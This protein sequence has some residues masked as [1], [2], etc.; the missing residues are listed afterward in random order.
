MKNY[1]VILSAPAFAALLF[2]ASG[3]YSA[4]QG[5]A[6]KAAIA[7]KDASFQKMK[8]RGRASDSDNTAILAPLAGEWN[9][10]ATFWANADAEGA[11]SDG[12]TT[13]EMVLN[14]RFLASSVVGVLNIDGKAAPIKGQGMIGYDSTKKAFTSV[15]ADTLSPGMMLGKGSYDSKTKSIK[16]TGQ[17]INPLTGTQDNFS[18]Q[19]DFT[20]PRTYKKTLYVVGK[21]GKQTKLMEIEYTRS[22]G[23]GSAANPEY[24]AEKP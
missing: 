9:Y 2:C 1:R 10:V 4:N 12:T 18:S 14:D 22:S 19:I 20:G 13:N 8:Q 21:S 3:A 5:D 16:E 24:P 7:E 15:W 11:R 17:F 6:E 23:A